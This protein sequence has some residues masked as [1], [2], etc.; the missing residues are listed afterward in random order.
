MKNK[1]YKIIIDNLKNKINRRI[2]LVNY[3]GAAPFFITPFFFL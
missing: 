3:P 1:K 2:T